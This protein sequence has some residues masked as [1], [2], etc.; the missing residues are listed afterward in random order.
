MAIKRYS[1]GIVGT[2]AS[3]PQGSKA[4]RACAGPSRAGLQTARLT[5]GT[6]A[7]APATAPSS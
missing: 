6:T 4:P 7:A 1:L 2:A 5:A 3:Q